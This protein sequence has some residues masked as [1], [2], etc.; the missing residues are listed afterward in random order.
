MS[1]YSFHI[2]TV[3]TYVALEC[4]A[5]RAEREGM[6]SVVKRQRATATHLRNAE[7]HM[8]SI[9]PEGHKVEVQI[10]LRHVPSFNAVARRT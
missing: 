7:A 2:S 9:C 4:E 10:V 6:T 8:Q 5:D 1:E 3:D